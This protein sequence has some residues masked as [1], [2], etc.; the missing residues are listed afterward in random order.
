MVLDF[1]HW[2]GIPPSLQRTSIVLKAVPH[3]PL[4]RMGARVVD[5]LTNVKGPAKS[6]RHIE[7]TIKIGDGSTIESVE[8]PNR[9][10]YREIG[11]AEVF[12]QDR[13]ANVK[14]LARQSIMRVPLPI[15]YPNPPLES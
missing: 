11:R 14:V 9:V 8:S 4:H 7:E 13:F 3:V 5:K 2:R 10:E 1:R 12:G 15:E 6:F